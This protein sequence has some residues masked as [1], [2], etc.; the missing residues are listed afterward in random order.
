MDFSVI[1]DFVKKAIA[2]LLKIL[3]V[4]VDEEFGDN[5]ESAVDDVVDFGKDAAAE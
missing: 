4:E 1:I 2:A 3:G 5:I